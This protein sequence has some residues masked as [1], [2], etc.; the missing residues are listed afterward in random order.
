[1]VKFV[2]GL[3]IGWAAC[4]LWWDDTIEAADRE[5]EP[6]EPLESFLRGANQGAREVIKI[7]RELDKNS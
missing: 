5:V 2:A 7:L 6:I 3:V 1:M 4:R